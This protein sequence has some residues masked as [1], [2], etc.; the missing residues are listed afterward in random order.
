MTLLIEINLN[1]WTLNEEYEI[2]QPY[3]PLLVEK[4]IVW[5]KIISSSEMHLIYGEKHFPLLLPCKIFLVYLWLWLIQQ[6]LTE[7]GSSFIKGLSVKMQ[8][9]SRHDNFFL[10][11]GGGCLLSQSVRPVGNILLAV[12][13]FTSKIGIN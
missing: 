7:Q 3:K 6:I 2:Y 10:Y 9:N 11:M 13:A 4:V 8:Q 12:L 5:Q 1:C